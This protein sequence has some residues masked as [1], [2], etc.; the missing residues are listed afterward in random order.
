MRGTDAGSLCLE[1]NARRYEEGS[2]IS[3]DDCEHK[4]YNTGGDF[5]GG[6]F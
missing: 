6:L 4:H 5:G 3:G 1:V 2:G